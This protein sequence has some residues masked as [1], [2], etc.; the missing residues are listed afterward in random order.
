MNK[1][2]FSKESV[3]KDYYI[4]DCNQHVLNLFGNKN[5]SFFYGKHPY[6]ISDNIQYDNSNA[7]ELSI[8]IMNAAYKGI[9]QNFEWKHR[10]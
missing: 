10:F 7:K 6:E 2:I 1:S 9:P 4:I 5:K 8:K 3:L